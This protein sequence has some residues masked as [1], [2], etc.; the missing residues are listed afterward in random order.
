MLLCIRTVQF[1]A[2]MKYHSTLAEWLETKLLVIPGAGKVVE[3][4]EA[5]LRRDPSRTAGSSTNV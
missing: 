4:P 3:P 2:A 1:K 5:V